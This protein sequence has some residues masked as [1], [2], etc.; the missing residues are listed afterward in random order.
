MRGPYAL[1]VATVQL[2]PPPRR[3]CIRL[4]F[5][6]VNRITQES[7]RWILM[8]LSRD[9][10]QARPMLSC[11]V[12]PSVCLYATFVNSVITSNCIFIFLP[13]A[14]HT[15]LVFRHRTS[16]QYSYGNPP[17][18]GGV[19]CRSGRQKSRFWANMWLHRV[20]WTVRSPGAIHL[21]AT[22]LDEASWWH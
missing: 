2:S 16:W 19:E 13:S 10:M 22:D 5:M 12:R 14:S 15:I 4:S 9:A 17:S 18:N 21:A 3:L 11:S 7:C 8:I 6:S 1:T 20:L